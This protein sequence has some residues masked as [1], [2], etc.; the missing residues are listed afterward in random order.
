MVVNP[1]APVTAAVKTVDD[2][3]AL[4]KKKPGEISYGSAGV[5]NITQ[6]GFEW[7]ADTAGIKLNH[8]P[9]KGV[10][11]TQA[12]L[13][14]KE[15]AVVLDSPAGI[16]HIKAG[17]FR[18]LAVTGPKRLP[19][20][21]DV[22]TMQELGYKDYEIGYWVGFFMRAG[23]PQT[24]IDKLNAEI[25]RIV[26][27]PEVQAKLKPQG[28]LAVEGPKAFADAVERETRRLAAIVDKANIKVEQ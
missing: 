6:L 22:P 16:P 24:I 12:A 9:Y 26:K 18:A 20:L 2:L 15:V 7:F 5:G 8:I 1:E 11:A 21:P 28:T 25:A 14:G 27:D 19:E 13:L 17:K 3:V 4:A 23:T 10:A